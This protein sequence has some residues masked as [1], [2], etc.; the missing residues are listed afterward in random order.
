MII[1][2][3]DWLYQ[4]DWQSVV[5][6]EY[7]QHNIGAI[8]N[9]AY[10]DN[11]KGI[12]YRTPHDVNLLCC[13]F[14]DAGKRL[15]V[16][17]LDAIMHFAVDF[18]GSGVLVHCMGG[19]NRSVIICALLLCVRESMSDDSACAVML[20]KN[21]LVNVYEDLAKKVHEYTGKNFQAMVRK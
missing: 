18:S 20:G 3:T 9:V 1:R 8:V 12:S 10:G 21:N 2:I 16:S 5:A 15:T 13:P 19:G 14:D 4:G 11:R 7:H 17:Q 6:S